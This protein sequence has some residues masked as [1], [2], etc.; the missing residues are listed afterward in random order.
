MHRVI[1]VALMGNVKFRYVLRDIDRYGNIR[2][3]FRRAKGTPK[4]ALKGAPGSVEFVTQYQLLLAGNADEQPERV[5]AKTFRWL[6][7]QYFSAPTFMRLDVS[8]QTYRRRVL[9]SMLQEPIRP[10]SPK[11]YGMMPLAAI[12]TKSLR[13]LRDRKADLP[14][15]ANYRV[16]VLRH[17]FKWAIDYEHM[18]SNPARELTRL[19]N[20]SQGFH[21]WTVEEV[22]QFEKRHL[23]GTKARL[24]LALLMW[25][26]VRR[27]D[28]VLLGRQHVRAG[29]LKFTQ[30]KNRNRNP[31][32]TEIPLLPQLHTIIEAS[33]TGDLT[34]LVTEYGLPFTVAGFGN[35]FRERCKEAGVPGS[36]HGLRK[37][38]A[39]TAAENGASTLQ[40]MSIFGWS[41]IKE[42]ERYTRA[43]ERRKMAAAAIDLLVR[44]PAKPGTEKSQPDRQLGPKAKKA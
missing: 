37:A 19:E 32:T 17:L 38:G 39:A 24:A 4:I 9:E 41:S 33:P 20:A 14:E 21:T 2:Y 35:W 44:R 31:V 22:E 16:K 3:Y 1:E 15:A 36:A 29:W 12:A 27:S 40:L 6:A 13:V 11:T 25:T 26:G 7:V 10:N 30:T 28:V 23:V 43:A 5:Q 42:A 34:F 8:T 18:R